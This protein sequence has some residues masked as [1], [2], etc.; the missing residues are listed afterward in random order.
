[1]IYLFLALSAFAKGPAPIKYKALISDV[2]K[3]IALRE[4]SSDK[5]NTLENWVTNNFL[6]QKPS[7]LDYPDQANEFEEYS[8]I[9]TD[10]I[11]QL[12]DPSLQSQSAL[13][14]GEVAS[15]GSQN[16]KFD[17]KVFLN[18]QKVSFNYPDKTPNNAPLKILEP[19]VLKFCP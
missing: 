9:L 1:M 5:I 2:N 10:L 15:K 7:A 14:P 18:Q 13:P 6:P 12:K 11:E 16:K 3:A 17:C 4:K 19:L 8:I